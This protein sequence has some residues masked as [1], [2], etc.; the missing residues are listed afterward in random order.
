MAYV[1]QLLLLTLVLYVVRGAEQCQN[2]TAVCAVTDDC[3]QV[4]GS[5]VYCVGSPPTCGICPT[6]GTLCTQDSQ[7]CSTAPSGLKGYCDVTLG[8]C[9]TCAALGDG[10]GDVGDGNRHC[11]AAPGLTCNNDTLNPR[12]IAIPGQPTNAPTPPTNAPTRA[13]TPAPTVQPTRAPTAPTTAPT[14]AP[15]PLHRWRRPQDWT[16]GLASLTQLWPWYWSPR[17]SWHWSSVAVVAA[18][19]EDVASVS[20]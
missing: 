20:N 9:I 12:C 15:T 7:C 4:N 14:P 17:P 2:Q 3:C 11:C 1:A 18:G 8:F 6:D 16:R 10:C 13:P 5:Y 19:R